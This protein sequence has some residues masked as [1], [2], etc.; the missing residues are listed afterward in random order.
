MKII[1]V[2]V[3]QIFLLDE[4]NFGWSWKKMRTVDT[5]KEFS[6]DVTAAMMVSLNKGTATML[7]VNSI[8]ML[9]IELYSYAKVF[10]C[11]E[12]KNVIIDHVSESTP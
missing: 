9:K 7:E 6:R 12:L 8:L 1:L 2:E 5:N 11:F 3:E 4:N 10:F